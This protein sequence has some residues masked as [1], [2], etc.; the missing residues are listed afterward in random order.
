M[1]KNVTGEKSIVRYIFYYS[2]VERF[3]RDIIP[4]NDKAFFFKPLEKGESVLL[5]QAT[6]Y[7]RFK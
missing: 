3:I 2:Q 4:T 1:G 7:N 6:E 5:H